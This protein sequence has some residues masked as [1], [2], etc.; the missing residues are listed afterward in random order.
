M[1]GLQRPW[2]NILVISARYFPLLP[3]RSCSFYVFLIEDSRATSGPLTRQAP[4]TFL[5]SLSL[6]IWQ[7]Y[8]N[9]LSYP[10]SSEVLNSDTC[11]WY[12]I[13]LLWIC[14]LW[15]L[16]THSTQIFHF[17]S[18]PST[19]RRLWTTMYHMSH[20]PL[21]VE[22]LFLLHV[23]YFVEKYINRRL[24]RLSLCL[25]PLFIQKV[26]ASVPFFLTFEGLNVLLSL[27]TL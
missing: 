13:L 11:N 18:V 1:L 10:R 20:M 8:P 15:L 9:H 17:F 16:T 4:I 6:F 19:Y 2:S 3:P 14:A 25:S 24:Q 27:K 5:N 26:A 21:I 22:D 23:M 12:I 7:I